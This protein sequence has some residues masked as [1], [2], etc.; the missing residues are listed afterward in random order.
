M[1]ERRVADELEIRE[2][3]A[4]YADAVCRRDTEAWG[5]TW[6]ADG[7]W[8]ILGQ[9]TA[10]R[11]AVVALWERLMGG[12][13]QVVQIPHEGIL[14]FDGDAAKG[15]WYITEYGQLADGTAM[16]T[17]GLY[18]DEYVQEDGA[19]RFGRRAF[20]ALYSGAPTLADAFHSLPAE[21][22]DGVF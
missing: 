3:V 6:A 18:H 9:T 1:T 17:L 8:A 10:G 14:Q 2:L 21:F 19:W 4:R 20:H 11:A 22:E 5:A 13:A 16:L 7:A 15:C 12:M